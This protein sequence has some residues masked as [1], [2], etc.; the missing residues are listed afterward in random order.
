MSRAWRAT[1][2]FLFI[3]PIALYV[4][5]GAFALWREGWVI[6]L[7]IPIPASWGLAYAMTRMGPKQVPLIRKT[8]PPLP[9]HWTKRDHEAWKI[10]RVVA[11]ETK[12]TDPVQ[13]TKIDFY[14]ATAER[15][16]LE[17]ARF[18]H[19]GSKDPLGS[20][21]IPEILA[22]AE[23]ALDRLSYLM[24]TQVPGS[25]QITL[26]YWRRLGDAPGAI[27]S[28]SNAY[29]LASLLFNPIGNVASRFFLN[30][31]VTGP[32]LR[33]LQ[34]NIAVWFFSTFVHEVGLCAIE[35]YS[36]RLS[37]GLKRYREEKARYELPAAAVSTPDVPTSTPSP[38][39]VTVGLVGQVKA[40]KSSLVNLLLREQRAATDVLPAT[41]QVTRYELREEELPPLVL[42]DTIGYS[43][44]GPPEAELD[45]T[46]K[47]I[48]QSDLVL[49]VMDALNPSRAPD[50]AL[51]T[52]IDQWLE[53]HPEFRPPPMLGVLTHI[54]QLSPALEWSPP[55][56]GWT[57]AEPSRAK[58]RSIKEAVQFNREQLGRRVIDI[59]PVCTDFE[60]KRTYGDD[61]LFAQMIALLDD[62]RAV[63][64]LRALHSRSPKGELMTILRQ[65]RAAGSKLL[66]AALGEGAMPTSLSK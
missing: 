39:A 61:Q 51:L 26:A 44:G 37:G 7:W 64:L 45:E 8:E 25:R 43:V 18:Y 27:K 15:I 48:Q 57:S 14:L 20:L 46:M 62:A 31:Y 11:E 13:L 16:G 6:W 59:A 22:A 60:R 12:T 5:L 38:A 53:R 29:Y 28:L 54:D 17:L 30:Q 66:Q 49:L 10:V 33:L 50:V 9:Q 34:E 3:A 56:D 55:Y 40:G 35:M 32:A 41:S 1:I 63:L 65:L 21:T 52:A 36:G 58:E 24:D 47:V 42:L 23:L 19:P 2:L 4:G